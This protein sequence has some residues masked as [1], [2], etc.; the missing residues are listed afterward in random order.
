MNLV[1]TLHARLRMSDAERGVS[2]AEVEAVL[3]EPDIVRPGKRGAVVA[4][5][6]VGNRRLSVVYREEG[7]RM[8]VIT[9]VVLERR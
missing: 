6:M 9:V 2:E 4:D 8:V 1:Y 3:A 7:D 5:K